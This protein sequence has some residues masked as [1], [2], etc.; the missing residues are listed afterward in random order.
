MNSDDETEKAV[1]MLSSI[2]K[3]PAHKRGKT[4][5]K[6]LDKKTRESL[7][8]AKS[9]W[10]LNQKLKK[11]ANQQ[12]QANKKRKLAQV[13]QQEVVQKEAISRT[14]DLFNYYQGLK[15]M[16]I[17][18]TQTIIK[19]KKMVICDFS[20]PDIDIKSGSRDSVKT[21][22]ACVDGTSTAAGIN[23]F[24]M[25]IRK[26]AAFSLLQRWYEANLKKRGVSWRTF[27]KQDH[28]SKDSQ[29]CIFCCFAFSQPFFLSHRNRRKN[30]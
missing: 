5:R 8:K 14:A 7:A 21:A 9:P 1:E 19:T 25:K 10:M 22:M 12:E 23:N 27:L 11:K 2:V 4:L 20:K 24:A 29:F 13:A 6:F 30:H 16:A 18:A 17:A 28:P 3:E 15:S 26:G